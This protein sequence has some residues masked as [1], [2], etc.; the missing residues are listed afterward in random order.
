ML[1]VGSM[2]VPSGNSSGRMNVPVNR[3]AKA[4]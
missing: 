3:V 4:V 1:P 2:I